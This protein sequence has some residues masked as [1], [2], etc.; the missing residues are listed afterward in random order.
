[1]FSVA[2]GKLKAHMLEYFRKVEETG[3]E[4]IVTDNRKPV[5]K[6]IPLYPKKTPD[7]VFGDLQGKIEYRGDIREPETEE[8]PQI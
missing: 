1:M 4:L 2:K 7:E 5:L 6:V 8:W 3:E